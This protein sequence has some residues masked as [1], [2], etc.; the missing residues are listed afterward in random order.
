VIIRTHG[1][2]CKQ[3][4]GDEPEEELDVETQRVEDDEL[5][6]EEIEPEPPKEQQGEQQ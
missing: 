4:I 2:E 3:E 5:G 6:E 1:A